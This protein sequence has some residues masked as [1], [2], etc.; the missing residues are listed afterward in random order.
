[1]PELMWA[2]PTIYIQ[3]VSEIHGITSGMSSSY[4][5]NKVYINIG[6]KMHSF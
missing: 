1:V 5:D 6:P 4:V 2:V 3:G